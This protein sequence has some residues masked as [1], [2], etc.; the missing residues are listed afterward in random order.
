[1]QDSP[2]IYEMLNNLREDE[3]R[4]VSLHR[5]DAMRTRA[6][7][8]PGVRSTIAGA[9]VRVGLLLDSEAGVRET[10]RRDTSGA[11]PRPRV[12]VAS[13]GEPACHW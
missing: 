2:Q 8:V 6:Q 11:W 9:I 1:M 12:I 7:T 4:R 13:E 3:L 10:D 5:I